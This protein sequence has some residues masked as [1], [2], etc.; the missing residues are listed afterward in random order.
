MVESYEIVEMIID[1]ESEG[2]EH[3]TTVFTH[4]NE[5]YSITFRKEDLEVINAWIFKEGTSLPANL[6]ARVVD[7]IR[8]NI[9]MR[10]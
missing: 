6:S 2:E 8:E 3:V 4:E 1:D 10:I 9:K 5:K 7:D